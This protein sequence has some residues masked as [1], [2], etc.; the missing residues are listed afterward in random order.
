MSY[1]NIAIQGTFVTL[2]AAELLGDKD[3]LAYSVDRWRRFCAEVDRT[4]SFAEYNS[5][6]Y[7]NVAIANLTRLRMYGR[8]AETMALV[9]K[10]HERFWKHIALH[11]H[12]PS[13][14][15][16]GPMSRCYSTD[17]GAPVWLQKA[18][19]NRLFWVA[20]ADLKDENRGRPDGETAMLDWAVP[21]RLVPYFL[22]LDKPR[23]H[24]EVFLP[25]AEGVRP[26]Q[27][28]TWLTPEY[29]LGSVNRGDF[30]VQRRPLLAYWGTPPA[31][32][33]ALRFLHDDYDFASAQFYSVQEK[34]WVLGWVNFKSPG[35]DKHP[36]LD[37]VKNGA[38]AAESLSL[39]LDLPRGVKIASLREREATVELA[40][41]LQLQFALD[42]HFDG[43]DGMMTAGEDGIAFSL[44][45]PRTPGPHTIRWADVSEAWIAFTLYL[46]PPADASK[47]K[48]SAEPNEWHTPAGVLALSAG[49]SVKPAAEQDRLFRETLNGKP[50]PLVRLSD[51]RLA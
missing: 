44:R 11:W 1:T 6:T 41:N 22:R 15:L 23:Q 4:G 19:D 28:T 34:N 2:C 50:V 48:W 7:A 32:Y 51:E 16:A 5:P 9:D 39:R 46:G 17:I 14:Q 27:G 3:L 45:P 29:A 49:K 43:W 20:L 36:S 26:V 47:W 42:D 10:V 25:A 13:K 37:M 21:E 40:P 33:A 24:R 8:H 30:W 31:R 38:F 35:G 12:A 18:L